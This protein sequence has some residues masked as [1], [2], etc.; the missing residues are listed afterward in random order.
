MFARI[1]AVVGLLAV[2]ASA[3]AQGKSIGTIS[4]GKETFEIV[5]AAAYAH[6]MVNAVDL[7][8]FS[9]PLPA[10][11]TVFSLDSKATAALRGL[12]LRISEKQA[13]KNATWMHPSIQGH[14]QFYYFG[15]DDP[16]V[17][18]YKGG[19]DRIS[20]SIVGEDR[21]GGTPIKVKLTFDLP[22]MTS[23]D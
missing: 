15:E 11:K 12:G 7:E 19:K 23:K 10:G 21:A 8:F 5:H 18:T 20:G 6:T 1:V 3:S 16:I 22:I 14:D 17:L 13:Y 2:S 4:F 9:S